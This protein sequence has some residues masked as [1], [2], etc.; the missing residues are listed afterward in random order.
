MEIRRS[1]YHYCDPDF[2]ILFFVDNMI[3]NIYEYYNQVYV[4]NSQTLTT[5]GFKQGVELY[6]EQGSM[7]K[8]LTR[9]IIKKPSKPLNSILQIIKFLETSGMRIVHI[10]FERGLYN[11]QFVANSIFHIV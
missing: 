10:P 5:N 8:V 11:V 6:M 1:G 2:G 7:L 9:N 3:D 4:I